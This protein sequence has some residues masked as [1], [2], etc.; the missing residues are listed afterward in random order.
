MPEGDAKQ[1][2][3][4]E[5]QDHS[6]IDVKKKGRRLSALK[7]V[8]PHKQPRK[9]HQLHPPI[10]ALILR[11]LQIKYIRSQRS[12]KEV[13]EKS[14]QNVAQQEGQTPLYEVYTLQNGFHQKT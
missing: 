4:Q 5:L 11:L 13:I 12:Q 3:E 14:L 6:V 8:G 10:T 2:L 9:G 7:D 1:A